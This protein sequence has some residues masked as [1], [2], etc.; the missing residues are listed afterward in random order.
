MTL[1]ELALHSVHFSVLAAK[2][3][4]AQVSGKSE[5]IYLKPSTA[6]WNYMFVNSIDSPGTISCYSVMKWDS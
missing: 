4:A 5:V 1:R 3:T 6:N 2:L